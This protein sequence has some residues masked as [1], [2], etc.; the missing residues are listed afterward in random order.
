MYDSV[1]HTKLIGTDENIA[2]K[3]K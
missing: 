2:N 3:L 1:F